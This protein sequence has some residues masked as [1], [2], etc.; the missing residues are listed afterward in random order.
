MTTSFE[1][2]GTSESVYGERIL[3]KSEPV[4]GLCV[5]DSTIERT[6]RTDKGRR[7]R[8]FIGKVMK[9]VLAEGE[10]FEEVM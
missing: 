6:A 8:N 10:G 4:V 2:R 5:K 1:L 7:E 3:A 9:V